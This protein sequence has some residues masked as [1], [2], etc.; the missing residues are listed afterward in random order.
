MKLNI[1]KFI[2]DASFIVGV[3]VVLVAIVLV[4]SQFPNNAMVQNARRYLG[5]NATVATV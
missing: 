2:P 1:K 5:L 4:A 3:C